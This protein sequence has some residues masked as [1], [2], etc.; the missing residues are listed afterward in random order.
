[1]CADAILPQSRFPI[2]FIIS[3]KDVQGHLLPL[4]LA[5]PL[6]RDEACVFSTA[7]AKHPEQGQEHFSIVLQGVGELSSL[8]LQKTGKKG[9]EVAQ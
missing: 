4:P 5:T 6:Q 7:P 1:M 2:K 9:W 3:Y 8:T